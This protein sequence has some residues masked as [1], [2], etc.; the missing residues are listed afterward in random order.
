MKPLKQA[1]VAVLVSL[2]CAM[3][4]PAASAYAKAAGS[5]RVVPASDGAGVVYDA[6]R[7]ADEAAMP[8]NDQFNWEMLAGAKLDGRPAYPAYDPSASTAATDGRELVERVSA[9]VLTDDAGVL[10]QALASYVVSEAKPTARVVSGEGAV[11]VQDGWYLL[12]AAGRRPLFAWVDGA[13]VELGDKSD[14]PVACKRVNTGAGWADA[15]VAGSGRAIRY[16]VD[17]CIPQTVDAAGSYPLTI[18]DAWDEQ[19]LLNRS[20]VRVEVLAASRSLASIDV[21]D[22]CS[23]DMDEAGMRISVGN[24]HDLGVAPGDVMRVS[25]TMRLADDAVARSSGWVGSAFAEFSAWTG[26]QRTPLDGARVYAVRIDVKKTNAAGDALA[27]AVCAVRNDD[28]WLA[29]DGTFGPKSKRAEFVSDEQGLMAGI[30]LLSDGT[31][32]VVELS[33]P[34]GYRAL[35]GAAPFEL[36]VDTANDSLTIHARATKPLR[37][38]AVDSDAASVHFGLEDTKPVGIWGALI[39]QTGDRSGMLAAGVLAFAGVSVLLMAARCSSSR[40]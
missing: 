33:A 3:V 29:S 34:R 1:V 10:A 12:T 4:L 25:Y 21:T 2:L 8:C 26:T 40:G 6:R 36:S 7:I 38:L 23:I 37:V 16:R 11:K 30:P 17:V 19:L 24:V 32:E 31:Y 13:A 5:L 20:T 18:V 9:D 39:P 22:A 28:G 15:A 14:T 35:K 27:G